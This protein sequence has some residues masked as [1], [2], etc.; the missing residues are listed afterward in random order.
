MSELLTSPPAPDPC[1]APGPDQ[2]ETFEALIAPVLD[3]AYRTA[4]R[5]LGDRADA[6]DLVQDA[7]LRALRG[8]DSFEPGT[9][10]GAWFFRILMNCFYSRHRR[11][12][13]DH[14]AVELDAEPLYL[15]RRA[16]AAGVDPDEDAAAVVMDALDAEEVAAAIDALPTDYRAVATLYFV[17]DLSYREIAGVLGCPVGTVRSR[18]HRSR[19]M[20]QQALWR[21]AEDRG[22]IPATR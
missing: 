20:L 14:D 10:F 21:V 15:Y 7:A 4:R 16:T 3:G 2:A 12:R 8:F 11:R 6:E 17:Q 19:R 18:L 5:L 22:T 9:N 13:P 1:L